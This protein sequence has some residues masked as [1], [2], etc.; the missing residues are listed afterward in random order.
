MLLYKLMVYK[1]T[2]K[3]IHKRNKIKRKKCKTN[4]KIRKKYRHMRYTKYKNRISRRKKQR[5]QRKRQKKQR[6]GVAFLTENFNET[7]IGSRGGSWKF[8]ANKPFDRNPEKVRGR[9]RSIETQ[10]P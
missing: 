9:R 1:R 2:R 5:K 6:G 8:N 4:K 3:R 7:I 10:K